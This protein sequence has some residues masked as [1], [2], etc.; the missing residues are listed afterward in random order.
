MTPKYYKGINCSAIVGKNGVGKSTILD[1]IQNQITYADL[2]GLIIFRHGN[3]RYVYDPMSVCNKI[4]GHYKHITSKNELLEISQL[5]LIKLTNIRE[6]DSS[7][8]QSKKTRSKL[9]F[10]YSPKNSNSRRDKQYSFKKISQ[11]LSYQK[12]DVGQYTGY[13]FRVQRKSIKNILNYYK[14]IDTEN[15]PNIEDSL[16]ESL[17]FVINELKMRGTD[18]LNNEYEYLVHNIINSQGSTFKTRLLLNLAPTIITSISKV[19]KR[20][21]ER[22][23]LLIVFFEYIRN[24]REYESHPNFDYDTIHN[25]I[26]NCFRVYLNI[27]EPN[28]I[29]IYRNFHYLLDP[30]IDT[31]YKLCNFIEKSNV[32]VDMN[33]MMATEDISLIENITSIISE[34]QP[35]ISSSFDIGWVGISSGEFAKIRIFS[36]LYEHILLNLDSSTENNN[37]VS[38]IIFIDEADLYLH[39]EWQRAFIHDLILMINEIGGIN[40]FQIIITS[41]SPIIISDLLPN[42]IISLHKDKVRNETSVKPALGFGTN[43]T[44]LFIDG[45]HISSTFGELSRI[46]IE[47]I[48]ERYQN[49]KLTEYDKFIISQI[50]NEYI[51]KQ[52]SQ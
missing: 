41:H 11:Y 23:I 22:P 18:D 14:L 26:T 13:A 3:A 27:V 20:G 15:S 43:I 30:T 5:S 24:L 2:Y 39:P 29:Q 9:L 40:K 6:L 16:L 21:D 34:F 12:D 10:D 36:E 28:N 7:I 35:L 50:G 37:P 49:N 17:H 32:S 44:D 4:E 1:F 48:L 33:G 46:K 31:I 38:N 42:N 45:M 52:L 19:I 51:R 8:N 25:I 47:E